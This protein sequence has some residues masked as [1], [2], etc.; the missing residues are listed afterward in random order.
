MPPRTRK[1]A[2]TKPGTGKPDESAQTADEAQPDEPETAQVE[3]PA[4]AQAES[5]PSTADEAPGGAGPDTPAE[6]A[7]HWESVNGDGSEPC[8]H[9]PPGAP[10][11]GAGSY[12]CP[13]GQ[14]VRV[15]D[16]P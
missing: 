7:Y 6:P 10:P 12:G 3:Q 1:S 13:H 15:L 14:W 5:A 8:R 4:H 2:D 9:C 16:A 11:P